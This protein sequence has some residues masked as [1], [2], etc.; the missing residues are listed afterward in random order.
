MA[1]IEKGQ[2]ATSYT[3]F[4]F[5]DELRG[6]AVGLMIFFHFSYDLRIF[7]FASIN[8]Q[9]DFFWWFLPRLIVFLFL[10]SMGLSTCL[11]HWPKF[12][13]R[14]FFIRLAKVG[15]GAALVSLVTY[16]LFPERWIYFGTLHCITLSSI[17]I[18]P[19]LGRPWPALILGL[20]LPISKW[21][22]GIGP[23]WFSLKHQSMDYI[24]F[25]PWFGIC[26]MG[27][28]AFHMGLHKINLPIPMKIKQGLQFFGRHSFLIYMLHQPLLYGTV[29]LVWMIQ[30]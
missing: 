1:P 17:A 11:G 3:R 21:G 5:V 9:R 12:K 28:F 29:Y 6:I 15:G 4:N 25:L 24:P 20:A 13:K 14:P 7:G 8:F 30:R 19:F 16:L 26:L 27:V 23:S 2:E 18:L 10:F 22:F